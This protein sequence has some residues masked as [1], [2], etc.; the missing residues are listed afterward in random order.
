MYD[1]PLFASLV[2]MKKLLL[3]S[4]LLLVACKPNTIANPDDFSSSSS[5]EVM[6][7]SSESS[8]SSSSVTVSVSSLSSSVSSVSSIPQATQSVAPKK[9]GGVYTTYYDG[10]IGNG[11]TSVLFFHAA[12]CPYCRTHDASL[13]AWYNGDPNPAISTYK[14]DFDTAETLKAQFGVVQQDTFVVI[15]G[16]GNVVQTLSFPSDASLEALIAS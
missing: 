16:Q 15:D 9:T 11:Q 7:S 4:A 8:V 2:L 12:W 5:S 10:V 3:V 14:I 1:A 6:T 13:S